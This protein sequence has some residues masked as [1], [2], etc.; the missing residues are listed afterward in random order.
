[1]IQAVFTVFIGGSTEDSQSWNFRAQQLL[2]RKS[3]TDASNSERFDWAQLL[4]LRLSGLYYCPQGCLGNRRSDPE[5]FEVQSSSFW[6]R[7]LGPRDEELPIGSSVVPFWD[8]LI[9]P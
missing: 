5:A 3:T 2:N 9:G 7:G 6:G 1:M 8:Y 4:N